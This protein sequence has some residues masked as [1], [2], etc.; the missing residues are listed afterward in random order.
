MKVSE[1]F[2]SSVKFLLL[3]ILSAA[4]LSACGGGGSSSGGDTAPTTTLTNE[5]VVLDQTNIPEQIQSWDSATGELVISGTDV[6]SGVLGVGS[7]LVMA[8]TVQA[9]GG[10]LRRVTGINQVSSNTVVA[11]EQAALSDV[12][13]ELDLSEVVPIS[14]S[15][16]SVVTALKSG[17]PVGS[18]EPGSV[19][20]YGGGVAN[21]AATT[22]CQADA[23][24]FYFALNNT[25]IRPDLTANGCIGLDISLDLQ[26]QISGKSLKK[27]RSVVTATQLVKVDFSYQPSSPSISFEK[28]VASFPPIVQTFW[29]PVGPVP[30]PI[31]IDHQTGI[32]IGGQISSDQNITYGAEVVGTVSNGAEY[33]SGTWQPVN[34]AESSA[35]A[36]TPSVS[37]VGLEASIYAGPKYKAAFYGLVGPEIGLFAY[38]KYLV[39]TAA[40]PWWKVAWNIALSLSIDVNLME[41]FSVGYN[42]AQYSL[43]AND[44][45]IVQSDGG[46]TPPVNLAVTSRQ[47]SSGYSHSIVLKP[48]GTV[49]SWGGD[50]IFVAGDYV[51]GNLGH[52]HI[53]E[54]YRTVPSRVLAV[55]DAASVSA[56]AHHSLLVDGAGEV[57]SW[58]D[59]AYGALG[60]G[61]ND[62][63]STP[64]RIPPVLSGIVSVIAG[65]HRSFAIHD[66]DGSV[67][68]WGENSS[69]ELGLGDT[70]GHLRP[71]L[72]PNLSGVADIAAGVEHTLALKTDGTV[73]SWGNNSNGQLGLGTTTS[74]T[75]PTTISGI[76]NVVSI[77]AGFG[78]SYAVTVDGLVYAWGRGAGG[79]LGIGDTTDRLAPVQIPGLNGVTQIE[80]GLFGFVVALKND[81]T[82]WQWGDGTISIPTQVSGLTGVIELSAG[83]GGYVVLKSDGT[84]ESWGN[85]AEGQLGDGTLTPSTTPVAVV[86]G[87]ATSQFDIDIVTCERSAGPTGAIV[88]AGD[89]QV[90]LSW[91]AVTGASAYHVYYTTWSGLTPDNYSSPPLPGSWASY[92]TSP[93]TIGGLT[94][95]TTYYFIVTAVVDGMESWASTE[96]NA[97]PTAIPI[98]VRPLNDT[99]ITTCGNDIS[100]LL[101]CPQVGYE[102]QDAEFGRDATANDDTDGHAGFSFTKI[103]SSGSPLPASATSWDCVL[104]NVTGLM[105]EVKT[106][107]SGLRDANHTYSWYNSDTATN[108]GSAGSSNGGTCF[109]TTNCDTEKYVAQVNANGGICGHTDWRMPN[110]MEL[111][112]LIDVSVAVPGP[113][114]DM[115][116][117]A[118]T[119]P[120]TYWSYTP[121]S[122]NGVSS[123][124]GITFRFAAISAYLKESIYAVRLVRTGR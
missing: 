81:G 102:G 61:D 37:S 40:D 87:C 44:K 19:M 82:V 85:N 64:T 124:R 91:N 84:L 10:L 95:D 11:T 58:G 115:A 90:T 118:N 59:N 26:I 76:S 45:V 53:N 49:W 77:A 17:I 108:G 41:K 56:G 83:G 8:P 68:S 60:T 29:V 46:Y 110:R 12:F 69:G 80:S 47:L 48:D 119:L 107:D 100:N 14:A 36:T 67:F 21:V 92:V 63:R 103:D 31:V 3:S 96:V 120:N 93:V 79:V 112:S 55:S 106:T 98:V 74:T 73:L 13:E 20:L 75:A 70:V 39:D 42:L 15:S 97:I 1:D 43:F 57:L 4:L 50:S 116:Y 71:D 2:A 6:E 32:V 34:A 52:G 78:T 62:P 35:S 122:D 94:N 28:N 105:W 101:T 27:F 9:P 114:I 16:P 7:V 33:S 66:N 111:S 30:V 54:W 65:W 18:G 38:I 117:F 24:T 72:I 109:D 23:Y 51:H 22:S 88:S 121:G 104:D 86:D 123:A 99:G 113:T 5:A 89:G 25:E